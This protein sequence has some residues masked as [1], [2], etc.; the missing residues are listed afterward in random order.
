VATKF[1]FFSD[2]IF[3]DELKFSMSERIPS[4]GQLIVERKKANSQPGERQDPYR[5][6]LAISGGGT[7]GV[8]LAGMAEAIVKHNILNV[9]DGIHG[10]SAGACIIPYMLDGQIDRGLG[11][12]FNYVPTDAFI[13]FSRFYKK[14]TPPVMDLTYLTQKV[15]GELE[16]VNWTRFNENPIEPH[17]YTTN[18]LNGQPKDNSIFD[19]R[20]ELLEDVHLSARMPVIG[21]LPKLGRDK[22]FYTDGGL[23][24]DG[25][26]LQQAI[27]TGATHV[28]LFSAR[29]QGSKKQGMLI[30][31]IGAG[32]LAATG[33]RKLARKVRGYETAYAK[34]LARAHKMQKDPDASAQIEVVRVPANSVELPLKPSKKQLLA[35]ARN[36]K[37]AVMEKLHSYRDIFVLSS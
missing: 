36:G 9:F 25:V 11:V 30:D 13:D 6:D 31:H 23:G 32:I 34:N 22:Q 19:D 37:E 2:K 21:G 29:R 16:P 15:M 17:I 14:N 1:S 12:F 10:V 20:E 33:L 27:D 28:L 4:V 24:T 5:L 35:A 3:I 18:A 26:P 8:R 7:N